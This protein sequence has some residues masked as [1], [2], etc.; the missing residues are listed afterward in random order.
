LVRIDDMHLEDNCWRFYYQ[1][2]GGSWDPSPSQIL[3]TFSRFSEDFLG[4]ERGG[5]P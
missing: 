2:P 1:G 4:R 3:G 5:G